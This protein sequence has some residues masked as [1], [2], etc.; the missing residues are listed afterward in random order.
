MHTGFEKQFELWLAPEKEWY[1]VRLRY[2]DNSVGYLDMVLT[3]L[4][5]RK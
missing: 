3:K 2:A 1:P 5:M 4:D